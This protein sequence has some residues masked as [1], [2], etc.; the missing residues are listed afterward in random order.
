MNSDF[1]NAI[2]FICSFYVRKIQ[3]IINFNKLAIIYILAVY[4]YDY[5]NLS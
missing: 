3:K 1:S 5:K 4:K 2:N